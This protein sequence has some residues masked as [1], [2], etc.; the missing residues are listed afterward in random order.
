MPQSL[1]QMYVHIVYSTKGRRPFL[2]DDDLRHRLHAYIAGI[3]RN[4]D[5]PAVVVGGVADHVHILCRLGKSIAIADLI[6]ELKRDSSK[7]VKATAP[8]LPM[9]QWQS[10]YGVFSISPSHVHPLTEYIREQQSHHDHES[11]QE[12]FRRLLT[13]CGV[14]FDEQYL[15]D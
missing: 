1:S 9:F 4:H 8:E 7:W 11:F 15:W 13:K 5:S 6:R 10:G 14:E 12:E 2:T 3:C